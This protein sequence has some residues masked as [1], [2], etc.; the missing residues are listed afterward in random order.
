M[1]ETPEA[2]LDAL[3]ENNDR[4]YNLH[5]T[6]TAEEL[7]DAAE[8]FDEP[9]L[10]VTAL[11]ELMSAYEYTGEHRKAPVVFARVLKLRDDS[12]D[13]FSDWEANQVLWRFK[14][15]TTSLLQVPE[16]PLAAIRGWTDQMRDRY[17]EAGHGMQPVAAMRHR[18]AAHVGSAEAER[19]AYDL[20]VT[21]P[22]EGMS[23]CEA[24]ET[25]HRAIHHVG[26]GDERRALDIWQPVFDGGQTCAEEPYV[27]QAHALLP[28]LSLGRVDEARSHHLSGYR[29][30]RGKTGLAE[31]VGLHVEFSALSRNEGRGLEILAENRALFETTG[32]PLSLLGFL[33]G[34]EVLL[35]RLVADGYGTTTVA[36]PLGRSWTAQSLLAHVSG[37]A[38]TLA[39]AFD[40]RNGTTG[41]GDRRRERVARPALLAEPLPLGLRTTRPETAPAPPVSS[42][43]IPDDFTELVTRA[44]EMAAVGHPGDTALWERIAERVA[45]EGHVHVPELGPEARLRAELVEQRGFTAYENENWAE[46]NA[47]MTEAA[48]L[49]AGEAA[50]PWHALAARAR[51]SSFAWGDAGDRE[52]GDFPSWSVLDELLGEA[53]ELLGRGGGGPATTDDTPDAKAA[54]PSTGTAVPATTDDAPPTGENVTEKYLTVLH[55]RAFAAHAEAAAEAPDVSAPTRARFDAAMDAV[56]SEAAR[57]GM[58]HLAVGVRRYTADLASRAGRADEAATELRTALELVET[59]GRPWRAPRLEAQLG[60]ILLQQ[61]KPEEATAS[62][63]Q[64]LAGAARFDD[65]TF[66]VAFTYLLLGHASSHAGD[67]PGAVRHLSEAAA[68]FDRES[69]HNAAAEARLQ[70]ADVLG[71][72]GQPADAVAVLES[73]VLDDASDTVDERLLAQI[74][75]N[76]ARGL[77]ELEEH[78][79]SAEQ[80]VQLAETVAAWEDRTTYTLVTAESAIAL[81]RADRWDAGR[82]AYERALLA[83]RDT[84]LPGQAG[85]ICEMAREF[86]ALTMA[87]E[88]P[89]GIEAALARL[90]EADEIRGAAAGD[91]EDLVHWYEAGATAYQRARA[92]AAAERFPEALAEMERAITA[93]EEGGEQGETPRAEATRVAALIEA[94][95]LNSPQAAIAR[96]DTAITR[97]EKAGIQHAAQILSAL[98]TDFATQRED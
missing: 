73:L 46:A 26:I 32:A 98:R 12:P 41:V 61:D 1:L 43:D 83:H 51:V 7:V 52:T 28:L 42:R 96:L 15:V 89:D 81:A 3:R 4:P 57:F 58:P 76:L 40:A 80:F 22:R 91:A 23:D 55:C 18:I 82:A 64:A 77:R 74:R 54:V 6:V 39:A 56:V 79:A 90:A 66:P 93:Y 34:V 97:C 19:S 59:S 25:R 21:R 16:V 94:N 14:W 35:T 70:L 62:L 24:C 36:G 5:R 60:Q 11:L 68:R 65:T 37:E 27:S 47:A 85:L 71:R 13:A 78:Q 53:R 29:Y 45:A 2:V 50:L 30:A 63:R 31:E 20:W 33:T 9:E 67:L 44:R 49:F 86:A 8:Q 17:R 84:R 92:L 48:D 69:D 38:D 95:G 75:L 10:L 72:S 87:A 88:G